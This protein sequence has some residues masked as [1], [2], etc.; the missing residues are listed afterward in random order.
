MTPNPEHPEGGA[1]A[2]RRMETVLELVLFGVS[3]Q[4]CEKTQA[5]SLPGSAQA[6]LT[7]ML[8]VKTLL[9]VMAMYTSLVAASPDLICSAPRCSA[10]VNAL[11]GA[12]L[13]VEASFITPMQTA[14]VGA[15]AANA[16]ESVRT[17]IDSKT[18]R[19]R[20]V[21][22]KLGNVVWGAAA[23]LSLLSVRY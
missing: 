5:S 11:N 19:R 18:D 8:R 9:I 12:K 4:R 22:A 7:S 23:V 6:R 1:F 17:T 13:K 16:I 2:I 14:G 21:R 3:S 15:A 10:D 20:I